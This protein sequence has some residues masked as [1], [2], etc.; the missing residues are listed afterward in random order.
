VAV[1]TAPLGIE[2]AVVSTSAGVVALVTLEKAE[3][4]D[5]L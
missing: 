5:A 2:G 4:P 1:A 3:L